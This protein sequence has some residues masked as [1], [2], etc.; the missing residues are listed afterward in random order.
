[1]LVFMQEDSGNHRKVFVKS[2]LPLIF[3]TLFIWLL[4][5]TRT[6]VAQE[7]LSSALYIDGQIALQSKIQDKRQQTCMESAETMQLH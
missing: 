4:L 3:Q 2:Y 5:F 1:M 6:M 7:Q